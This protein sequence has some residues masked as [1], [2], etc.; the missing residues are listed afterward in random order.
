MTDN[1]RP[2]DADHCSDQ[3]VYLVPVKSRSRT[4]DCAW[5][6]SEQHRDEHW[7][8][9]L[10]RDPNDSSQLLRCAACRRTPNA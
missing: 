10:K 8:T 4:M 2:L 9:H 5:T 1:R 3:C 6:K 7:T